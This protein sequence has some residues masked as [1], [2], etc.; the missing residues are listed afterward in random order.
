M[1]LLKGSKLL[2]I[3][4]CV[5]GL[6]ACAKDGNQSR[7]WYDMLHE[8]QRQECIA[9]GGRDCE[10]PQSYEQYKAQRNEATNP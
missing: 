6:S 7:L 1:E 4:A 9:A 3:M 8:R 10:R 2:F 5:A